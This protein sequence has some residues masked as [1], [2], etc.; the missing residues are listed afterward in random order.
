MSAFSRIPERLRHAIANQLGFTLL[1]AVQS[2]PARRGKYVVVLAPTAGG[3]TEASMFP[4]ISGLLTAP[5]SGVGARYVVLGNRGDSGSDAHSDSDWTRTR[6]GLERREKRSRK[7]LRPQPDL[8]GPR[9]SGAQST[10][11][12]RS[13]TTWTRSVHQSCSRVRN[14]RGRDSSR[15]DR[16]RASRDSDRRPGD[17]AAIFGPPPFGVESLGVHDDGELDRAARWRQVGR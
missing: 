10:T 11:W 13:S 16:R 8:G 1:R 3:K 17:R 6:L 14:A 7:R 5:P 2:S 12:T 4:V 9:G 15:S